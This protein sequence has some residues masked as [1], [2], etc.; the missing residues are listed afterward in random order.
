MDWTEL[1]NLGLLLLFDR[2]PGKSWEEQI[3]CQEGAT[4]ETPV[5]RY[6]VL[7]PKSQ[8]RANGVITILRNSIGPWSPW[9]RIGPSSD[10]LASSA[11]AVSP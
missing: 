6:G 1:R 10:S 11:I 2:R 3:S 4:D 9:S 8:Y 7:Q 5:T